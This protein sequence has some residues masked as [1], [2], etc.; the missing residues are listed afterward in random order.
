[1]EVRDPEVLGQ[2]AMLALDHVRDGQRLE[3]MPVRRLGV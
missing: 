3:R 1:V 2:K